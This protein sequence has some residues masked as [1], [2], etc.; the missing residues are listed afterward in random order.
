M[1]PRSWLKCHG[2]G[3]KSTCNNTQACPPK[4][5][6]WDQAMPLKVNDCKTELTYAKLTPSFTHICLKFKQLVQTMD[7]YSN[8]TVR[9]CIHLKRKWTYVPMVRHF[10]GRAD[11]PAQTEVP[12]SLVE[13]TRCASRNQPAFDKKS[14]A[15]SGP[16]NTKVAY[17]QQ[18]H[19][20]PETWQHRFWNPRVAPK[21]SEP[22]QTKPSSEAMLIYWQV[23]LG[24]SPFQQWQDHLSWDEGYLLSWHF[25]CLNSLNFTVRGTTLIFWVEETS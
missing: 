9:D 21:A 11:R 4:A 25:L 5:A 2:S 12:V 8:K 22:S 23:H 14:P 20:D 16:R 19:K 17:P 7:W 18:L 24:K 6:A 10:L 1:L 3:K 15:S 13:Q